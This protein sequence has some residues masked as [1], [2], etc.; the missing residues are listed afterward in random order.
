MGGHDETGA[1]VHDAQQL[2]AAARF[3]RIDHA[4]D[5]ALEDV[6]EAGGT[7][8]ALSWEILIVVPCEFVSCFRLPPNG[9]ALIS[10]AALSDS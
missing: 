7:Q 4:C 1:V 8:S 5:L 9:T 10:S 2:V 6:G 3:E